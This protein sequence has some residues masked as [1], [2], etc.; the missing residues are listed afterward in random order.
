M[1][2]FYDKQNDRLVFVDNKADKVFW[3]E[4]WSTGTLKDRKPLN[5]NSWLV[6]ITN[7]Y[8]ATGSVI[9]EGG[10]GPGDNVFSLQ[11]AGF[12]AYGIDYAK[13]TVEAINKAYPELNIQLG[14]VRKTPF[15]DNFFDGYWSLGVI[16]HFYMGYENI[17][18]EMRRVIKPGGYLFLTF[19]VMSR[20]RRMK[21]FCGCYEKWEG[22]HNNIESFYQFA[23]SENEVISTLSK[24][25]FS[26]IAKQYTSAFKGFKDEIKIFAPCMQKIYESRSLTAKLVK[27]ISEII[28]NQI[29][30]HMVLMIFKKNKPV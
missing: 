28:L 18:D 12:C 29:S 23:L 22:N 7:K 10:C 17:L 6:N 19:P 16:E 25:G 4:H 3:D 15:V 8:L 13:K 27:G 9:L 24:N 26:Y 21:A 1:N 20:L 5:Y 30:P 2:K 14:D 11:E